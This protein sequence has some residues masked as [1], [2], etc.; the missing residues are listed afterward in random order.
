MAFTRNITSILTPK[1]WLVAL[2][3]FPNPAHDIITIS[4]L[5]NYRFIQISD[6]NGIIRKEIKSANKD[7]LEISI[8][9]FHSGIY[10]I[11][12]FSEYG[13]ITYRIVKSN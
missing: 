8:A 4:G 9:D 3:I 13:F 12:F 5:R 10:F 2:K 6:M 7:F 1:E 11:K